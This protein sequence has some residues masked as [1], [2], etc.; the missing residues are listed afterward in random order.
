MIVLQDADLIVRVDPRH[1]GEIIDFVDLSTG[2]QLLGRPPFGSTEPVPGD[3]DP[4]TW[5]ASYR[6]GWQ[7]VTPNAGMPCE[8]GDEWHGFHG[9]A[10]ADSWSMLERSFDRAALAWEGHGVW[11]GRKLRLR[12]GALHV[13]TT[14]TAREQRVPL[15]AVEHVALGLE[16]ID[17]EVRI[18]LPG[19]LAFELSETEGPVT[20]PADATRWPEVRLLDGS[21]ERADLWRLDAERS[22]YYV[23]VDLPEGSV[24]VRN[25][26]RRQSIE[27]TWRTDFLRHLWVW[28]EVRTY[29][30]QWCGKTEMLVVEPASVP[31]GNGLA[32]AIENDQAT[33]LDPGE[34]LRYEL[35]ARPG[36]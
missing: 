22:R 33:W 7:L 9:Q 6:G 11:I 8:V 24:V 36:P 18:E 31:H 17:P 16:L 19:G 10:S 14:F 15:V 3:L 20:T 5:S 28:H 13:E 23:V 25:V 35:V 30:G 32:A 2:R 34:T 1:G 27:L 4:D 12:D 21:V 26:A 29:P